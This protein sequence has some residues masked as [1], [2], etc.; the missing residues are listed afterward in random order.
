MHSSDCE[1]EKC[2]SY[3][4]LLREQTYNKRASESHNFLPTN[5][6]NLNDLLM[7][8]DIYSNPCVGAP[9]KYQNDGTLGSEFCILCCELQC[10][11]HNDRQFVLRC[12][13][14]RCPKLQFWIAIEIGNMFHSANRNEW[15]IIMRVKA[16]VAASVL[17][18]QPK[19]IQTKS[20]TNMRHSTSFLAKQ[21]DII[22]C[23]TM[24]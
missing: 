12:S 6:L 17:S 10:K 11:Q 5:T 24:C 3:L 9:E 14:R 13:Q 19:C 20:Q 7:A 23:Q 16:L 15:I 4:L 18:H 8:A 1:Q 21:C 2:M 22:P